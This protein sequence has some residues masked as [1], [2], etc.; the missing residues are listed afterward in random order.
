MMANLCFRSASAGGVVTNLAVLIAIG[1]MLFLSESSLVDTF[2]VLKLIF[3]LELLAE[4]GAAPVPEPVL[5]QADI[6]ISTRKVITISNLFTTFNPAFE[7]EKFL[8]S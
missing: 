7:A 4:A 5:L 8:V 2:S 6:V 1:L 3:E